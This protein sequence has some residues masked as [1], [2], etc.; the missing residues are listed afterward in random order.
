MH[1]ILKRIRIFSCLIFFL[2][3]NPHLGSCSTLRDMY[4]SAVD[5]YNKGQYD[6]AIGIYEQIIKEM[7]QFP[8][9]YIGLGLAYFAGNQREKALEVITQLKDM[10]QDD[11]A[12]RLEKSVRENNKVILNELAGPDTEAQE[13]PF[14]KT[15]DTP[16][17]IKVRL[18]GK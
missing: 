5:S 16:K 17:G 2:L 6:Q 9:A 12:N 1:Q 14:E 4:E 8:N 11:F 15:P 7:P 3:L 18:K 13:K 10:G